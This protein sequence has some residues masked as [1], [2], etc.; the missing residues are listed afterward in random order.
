MKSHQPV[1]FVISDRVLELK[2]NYIYIPQG[3]GGLSWISNTTLFREFAG[4]KYETIKAE[5]TC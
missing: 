5:W 1:K 2:C 3:G 4:V